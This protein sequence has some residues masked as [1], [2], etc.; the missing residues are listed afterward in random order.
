MLQLLQP[1]QA[2]Q[3][4]RLHQQFKSHQ[5][6][7]AHQCYNYINQ[8]QQPY[9]SH[10]DCKQVNEC[11]SQGHSKNIPSWFRCTPE[12]LFNKLGAVAIHQSTTQ[13]T[14]KMSN[15]NDGEPFLWK[16][17]YHERMSD[18]VFNNGSMSI[19]RLERGIKSRTLLPGALK[20][21]SYGGGLGGW[22]DGWLGRRAG[23]W[24]GGWNM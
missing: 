13:G 10:V 11:I 3:S 4:H 19:G 18:A 24:A 2:Y 7:Q 1:G 6:H 22:V 12:R 16:L 15:W 20:C 14:N 17:Q 23:K 5:L 21:S 8:L 9:Q